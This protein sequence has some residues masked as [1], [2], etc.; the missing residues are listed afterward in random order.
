M[1]YAGEYGGVV[2]REIKNANGKKYI[3]GAILSPEEVAEW[4]L[5]NRQA[6]H[7]TGMVDWYG[8]PAPGEQAARE[9]GKPAPARKSS[10]SKPASATSPRPRRG[11]R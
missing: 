10:A 9:S 1:R 8:P 7:S 11:A 6:L 3:V 2:K 4:P 5:A